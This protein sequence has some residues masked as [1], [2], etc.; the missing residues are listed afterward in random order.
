MWPC[1]VRPAPRAQV[2]TGMQGGG[3]PGIARDDEGDAAL[4]AKFGDGA[5]EGQAIRSGIMAVDD[6][7]KPGGQGGDQGEWVGQDRSIG[8]QP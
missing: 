8:E 7:A 3:E 4:P 6:A 2:Q 1:V 5:A